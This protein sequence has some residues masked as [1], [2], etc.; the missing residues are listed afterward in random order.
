MSLASL[1]GQGFEISEIWPYSGPSCEDPLGD[2]FD[3]VR[4]VLTESAD[5]CELD[6]GIDCLLK[7]DRIFEAFRVNIWVK[8]KPLLWVPPNRGLFLTDEDSDPIRDRELGVFELFGRYGGSF[9]IPSEYESL[10]DLPYQFRGAL[11]GRDYAQI[12]LF[13]IA[14]AKELGLSDKRTAKLL[15]KFNNSFPRYLNLLFWLGAKVPN[16]FLPEVKVDFD[17]AFKSHREFQEELKRASR[18]LEETGELAYFFIP[19]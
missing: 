8:Q 10:C 3:P 15:N 1:L 5:E 9:S 12:C 16:R 14:Q 11:R 19:K 6:I 7:D 13:G 17:A 2:A 18:Y 4:R